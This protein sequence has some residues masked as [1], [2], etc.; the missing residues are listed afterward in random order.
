MHLAGRDQQREINE[1][2]VVWSMWVT[3]CSE[4]ERSP[5]CQPVS[6]CHSFVFGLWLV[7][8]TYHTGRRICRVSKGRHISFSGTRLATEKQRGI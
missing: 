1:T 7:T 3:C 5:S 4:G 8:Q 2:L 6:C